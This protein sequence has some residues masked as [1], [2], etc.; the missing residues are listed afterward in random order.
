M[1]LVLFAD[2][3]VLETWI[4]RLPRVHLLN[5]AAWMLALV[6]GGIIPDGAKLLDDI[7]PQRTSP[8]APIERPGPTRRVQ[9]RWIRKPHEDV[10]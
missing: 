1:P 9:S 8:M 6:D 3:D 7:N 4:A 10:G 5:P 2:P